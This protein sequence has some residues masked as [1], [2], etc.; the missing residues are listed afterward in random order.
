[1]PH[2]STDPRQM[3]AAAFRVARERLGL[4]TAWTA[5]R[6]GV[7]ER[8]VHRWEAGVSPVPEGV[9]IEMDYVGMLTEDAV[10][11]LV[12]R[13]L[14]QPQPTVVTYRTDADYRRADPEQPWPA[15]WHRA[16]TARV[17]QEVPGLAIEYWTPGG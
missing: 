15:S 4:T 16:V 2:S 5:D 1:M 10:N 9:R 6:M 14:D 7:Q 8:T 13:L 3:T 12:Q 17:A 11:A